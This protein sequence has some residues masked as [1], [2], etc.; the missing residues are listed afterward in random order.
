MD[1]FDVHAA[2]WQNELKRALDTA[3][4]DRV[5]DPVFAKAAEGILAWDGFFTPEA[6]ATSLYKFWR[7][8]VGT[9]LQITQLENGGHFDAEQQVKL[10][11]IL[12][13]TIKQM[14]SKYG[15]WDVAWGDIH[16]VGRGEKLF[17]APGADFQSGPKDLNFSETLLDVRSKEDSAHR[18]HYIAN[19]G[20]MAVILM[21]FHK[22]GIQS[23]TCT[24]WGQSSHSQSPHYA[25]QAEQLYSKRKMKPTWWDEKE[26]RQN[27]ESTKTLLVK[28]R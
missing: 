12:Q 13:E 8:K 14:Q 17:P 1:I 18:D 24:P 23:L 2:S 6:T 4:Q 27:L 15:K 25:D 11:V 22:D 7:L 5:K 3:G 10:L 19:S 21:F 26:L 20:S 9:E 28:Q 16:K